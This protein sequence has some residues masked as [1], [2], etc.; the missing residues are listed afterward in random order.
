MN[1]H[2]YA[3]SRKERGLRGNVSNVHRHVASGKILI[4]DNGLID[5]E[6]ADRAWEELVDSGHYRNGQAGE[7]SSDGIGTSM[8]QATLAEK[9]YKAKLAKLEYDERTGKL[10]P[11]ADITSKW[12]AFL[13]T[14][15]TKLLG[16]PSSVKNRDPSLTMAQVKIVEDEI[17]EALQELSE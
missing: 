14:I 3:R 13:S 9:A 2:Q 5:S 10:V 8:A 6:Q 11:I 16:V 4:D 17:R 1:Q 15:R 7:E 12:E